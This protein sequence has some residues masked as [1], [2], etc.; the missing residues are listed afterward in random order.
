MSEAT[1]SKLAVTASRPF[2]GPT[3][4]IVFDA[5]ELPT[6]ESGQRIVIYDGA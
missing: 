1:D 4:A 3:T 5:T 6:L 2:E